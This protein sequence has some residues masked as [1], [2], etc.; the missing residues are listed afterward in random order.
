MKTVNVQVTIQL[1]IE[2]VSGNVLADV[3]TAIE[4]INQGLSRETESNYQAQIF[5]S[6]IDLSDITE[7]NGGFEVG[8]EVEVPEPNNKLG[9]IHNHSF[10]GVI[11]CFRGDNAV[12]ED[13]EGNCF[14]IETER[15]CIIDIN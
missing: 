12:V 7:S 9:D 15:L 6:A 5:T 10:V 13:G 2:T 1:D 8:D 3:Q 11:A 4:F 14:E